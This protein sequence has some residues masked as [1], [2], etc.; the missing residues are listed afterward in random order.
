MTLTLTLTP[1][2]ETRLAAQ[3]RRA[4][5]TPEQYVQSL[6]DRDTQKSGPTQAGGAQPLS[7]TAALFAQWAEEDRT[8]DSEEIAR[9]NQ[10]TDEL[11]QAL[12]DHPLSFRRIDTG[13][14]DAKGRAA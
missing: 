3:A 13:E 4:G 10:E 12:A 6:I 2:K 1:E 8:D 9:R 11:L 5:L 14:D 7:P